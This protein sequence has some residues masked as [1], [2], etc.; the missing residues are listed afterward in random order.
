MGSGFSL[1]WI[2]SELWAEVKGG[3]WLLLRRGTTLSK[4]IEIVL[5]CSDGSEVSIL[6]SV[7]DYCEN[8][9]FVSMNR[10]TVWAHGQESKREIRKNVDVYCYGIT[11]NHLKG[12]WVKNGLKW[13][14]NG[15]AYPYVTLCFRVE[16]T[17]FKKIYFEMW[18]VVNVS[19]IYCTVKILLGLCLWN[20]FSCIWGLG[21]LDNEAVK[22]HGPFSAA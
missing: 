21:R 12:I 4:I 2:M 18:L 15:R 20:V 5:L 22:I 8:S 19:E 6:F 11:A 16:W 3:T 13:S 14:G 1:L 17:F 10:V 9:K 7:S